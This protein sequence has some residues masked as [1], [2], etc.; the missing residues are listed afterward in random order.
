M[1]SR[2]EID[3]V[4]EPTCDTTLASAALEEVGNSEPAD[5]TQ[6]HL[7]YSQSCHWTFR[8]LE[9]TSGD[10]G[11][12]PKEPQGCINQLSHAVRCKR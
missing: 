4:W 6:L 9:V 7:Q 11:S 1:A 12:Q 8:T 3:A 2:E 10:G 5:L